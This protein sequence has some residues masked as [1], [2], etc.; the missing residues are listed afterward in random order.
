MSAEVIGCWVKVLQAAVLR[1]LAIGPDYLRGIQRSG[2]LT[3]G[4]E[5]NVLVKDIVFSGKGPGAFTSVLDAMLALDEI[6]INCGIL[7]GMIIEKFVKSDFGGGDDLEYAPATKE[8]I[9]LMPFYAYA[10]EPDKTYTFNSLVKNFASSLTGF[11]P[12]GGLGGQI[13]GLIEGVGAIAGRLPST[14]T[15]AEKLLASKEIVVV[16][17][18]K[19]RHDQT[20]YDCCRDKTRISTIAKSIRE[21]VL[22]S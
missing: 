7:E 3:K 10:F 22:G 17:T 18:G 19:E 8:D 12:G 2:P 5:H 1:D 4:E 11:I 14:K 13:R 20:M 6:F 9:F 21:V 15:E 16:I